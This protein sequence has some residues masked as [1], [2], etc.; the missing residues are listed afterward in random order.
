MRNMKYSVCSLMTTMKPA[1]N[2]IFLCALCLIMMLLTF[3]A[4]AT[5]VGIVVS[6]LNAESSPSNVEKM[7][8]LKNLSSSVSQSSQHL[9]FVFVQN[10][11]SAKGT[12]DAVMEL[13]V[14]DVDIVLLPL[15]SKEA[16]IA[17]RILTQFNTPFVTSA[18]STEVIKDHKLGLSIM[19]S[20]RIQ[21]ELL[22]RHFV[23]SHKQDNIHIL[24]YSG[25][26]YSS[27]IAS[28]FVHALM[29]LNPDTKIF[30]ADYKL[31][32]MNK[33][34]RTLKDGDVVFAP[35]FN[36][37]IAMVYTAAVAS[38]KQITILG[39]DSVGG[40]SEFYDVVEEF[41][42]KVNLKF[43]KNWNGD[44][45]GPNS[46][47]LRAYVKAYCPKDESTFLTTY[48][49]DLL[50]FV[51]DESSRLNKLTSKSDAINVLRSSGY[52]TTMDGSPMN[53]DEAGYNYKPMYLYKI[54]S[55]GNQL[56]QTLKFDEGIK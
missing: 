16:Q 7:C 8:I 15:I 50:R 52:I 18:S 56:I 21:A 28:Q 3:Q 27:T 45:K 32:S 17:S 22:A 38:Q 23:R 29:K 43:V 40:R 30:N 11:R 2:T 53:F 9:D 39:T 51:I 20:N 46:R 33:F 55:N 1:K 47:D 25:D 4:S 42:D 37:H 44:V 26:Q 36:P 41:S 49:Y 5:K 6:S 54:T 10:K 24:R 35:L 13:L 31:T 12:A 48:S 14:K 19:P 34:M